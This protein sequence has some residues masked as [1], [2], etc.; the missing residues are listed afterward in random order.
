[1]PSK[2]PFG[3]KLAQKNSLKWKNQPKDMVKGVLD[4]QKISK[5]GKLIKN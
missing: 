3:L 1:M 5:N 2:K 4:Y